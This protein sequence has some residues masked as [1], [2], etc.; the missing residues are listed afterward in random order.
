VLVFLVRFPYGTAAV[1]VLF[2]LHFL[3]GIYDYGSPDMMPFW[4]RGMS[5]ICLGAIINMA[6]MV[7]TFLQPNSPA[8]AIIQQKPHKAI[9]NPSSTTEP[10]LT[11]NNPR[12]FFYP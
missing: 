9:Y 2:L 5:G 11:L 4:P 10:R 7:L 6:F 12:G 8:K 1:A 3:Q